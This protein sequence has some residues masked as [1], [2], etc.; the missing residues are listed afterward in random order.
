MSEITHAIAEEL[1]RLNC[2]YKRKYEIL[3]SLGSSAA[4]YFWAKDLDGNYLYGNPAFL[5]WLGAADVDELHNNSDMYF[6]LKSR[7]IEPNNDRFHTFGEMCGNSDEDTL[8][9]NKACKYFEEGVVRGKYCYWEVVKAPLIDAVTG[10]VCGV[11]GTSIDVTARVV[12]QEDVV[13]QLSEIV[14]KEA[15]STDGSLHDN[16]KNIVSI[17]RDTLDSHKYT[18]GQPR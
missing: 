16:L 2:E 3:M 9:Q 6:A 1:C 15:E 14:E 10:A 7:A 12:L 18:E 17:L 4:T 5:S 11:V 13:T 8:R